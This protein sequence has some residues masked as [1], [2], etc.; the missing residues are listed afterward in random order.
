MSATS[1]PPAGKPRPPAG[2]TARV[3]TAG[4]LVSALCFV[5]GLGLSLAGSD[6]RTGDPLRL[7]LVLASA[8][9]IEPW[10]WSTLGVLALLATPAVGLVVSAV[11]LR[12]VEPRTALLAL[13][14]LGILVLAVAIALAAA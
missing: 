2:L 5:A 7:D 4:T 13:G 1:R 9:A 6:A 8:L 11:E 10:G 14:V 3:L 12:T